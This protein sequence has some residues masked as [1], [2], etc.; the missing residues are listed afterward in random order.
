MLPLK[1]LLFGSRGQVGW[2]LQRA[3]SLFGNVV[4]ADREKADFERPEELATIVDIEGPSIIVNA[5][6]YTA[7]DRAETDAQRARTINAI[8]VERLARA[9]KKKRALLIHYST[10]YVYD[11]SGSYPYT[12]NQPIKPMSVYGK[13][14]SEGDEAILMSGC[15]HLI[16][17]TSWVHSSRGNNFIRKILRLAADNADLTIVADQFGAPTS[18]EMIADVTAL[19]IARRTSGLELQSGLYHLTSSGATSWYEFARFIVGEAGFQGC[20]LKARA[21]TIRPISSAE[22][23]VAASRPHNSIM[24]TSKLSASLNIVFPDWT[25][26][27]RRTI[28]EILEKQSA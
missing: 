25:H 11:G 7:V 27:V 3:L 4:V 10:D 1:I 19:A 23:R 20:T 18:A 22:F 9:A 17:R 8:A 28:F 2:E 13:T 5:A 21:E 24:D 16:F 6:A 12:E 26:H 15:D 14:K